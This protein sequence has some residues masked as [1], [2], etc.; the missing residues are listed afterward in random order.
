MLSLGASLDSGRR[1]VKS[2]ALFYRRTWHTG[3]V[4][5][6]KRAATRAANVERIKATA[7]GLLAR[8][9]ASALSLREVAR[10]MNQSS[11]A[12][13][14]YFPNRDELLTSL[15][16]D[17][18][19]DLGAATER[20]EA[21][22]PRADFLGRWRTSCRAIRRWAHSHPHE[23]ALIFGSPIPGYQAPEATVAAA[24]RV[25]T[26]IATIVAD[27]FRTHPGV[28]D[29]PPSCSRLLEWENI[30]R[31]M[32]GVPPEVAVRAIF[33]WTEIFG[34]LSFELF[35][36]LVGSV[37]SPEATFAR[38]IDETASYVGIDV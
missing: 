38:L 15:I 37:R 6:A 16:I 8:H 27:R 25:I 34:F 19:N 2:S 5:S 22:T 20:A 28:P 23:Y 21:R 32:P 29:C 24:S 4:E 13:Y 35:G 33:V 12:L 30:S 31:L 1:F 36:H 7:R 18:Y 17:A 10:E 11:S 14:R 9:G 3:S 26:V